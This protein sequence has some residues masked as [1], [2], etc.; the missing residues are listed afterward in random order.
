MCFACTSFYRRVVHGAAFDFSNARW[1]ADDDARFWNDGEPLVDFADEVV[2]HQL[3]DI[4]IADD[5]VF[6][7]S[8]RNDIRGRATNHALCI[9]AYG[10][11][12]FGLGINRNN[13]RF[14]D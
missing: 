10:E 6:E 3:G 2:E 13:R 1:N 12:S 7:W 4:E 8:H 14:V 11:R 5:T 9:R